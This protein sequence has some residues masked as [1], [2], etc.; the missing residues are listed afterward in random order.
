MGP[1]AFA[2]GDAGVR[3]AERQRMKWASMGP[4][5]FARGDTLTRDEML[6]AVKSLQWGRELSPAEMDQRTAG[7][8]RLK[9]LQ[10]GRELSPAEMSWRVCRRVTIR[11]S[12]QWGR[13]L[14]PAEMSGTASASELSD[15]ASM[16][17]R[18]FARGDINVKSPAKPSEDLLQWGRELSP[19]EIGRASVARITTIFASMGPRAFARGDARR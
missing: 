3:E 13:E 18:A 4:R 12:L 8:E 6:A 7:F 10:W 15:I 14:S 9:M 11:P 2:R 16:G 19:A 17:P 5:A 1:R